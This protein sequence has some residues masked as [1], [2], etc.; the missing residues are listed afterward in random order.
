MIT[1]TLNE[2]ISDINT[3]AQEV[4]EAQVNLNPNKAM[5][6]DGVSQKRNSVHSPF[7]IYRYPMHN[8]PNSAQ[9]GAVVCLWTI[10]A[11]VSL[12]SVHQAE[13]LASQVK[14]S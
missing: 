4:Y 12:L 9:L 5:G 6:I 1:P 11:I 13:M 7:A 14:D 3:T 2:T 10:L 8:K